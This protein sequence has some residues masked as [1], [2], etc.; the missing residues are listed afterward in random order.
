MKIGIIGSG[1]SGL[2]CAHYLHED[3]DIEI[4]ES[5]DWIG[6]HTHTVD[7]EWQG[8]THAID[9]G[10]IVFNQLTYPNFLKLL[11]DCEVEYQDSSMS[12]G[13][14]CQRTGLEYNA[15]SIDTLFAQRRNIIRPSFWLI[16][17]DI[18]RFYKEADAALARGDARSLGRYLREEGYSTA[19]IEQHIV[20]MAAAVWSAPPSQMMSFPL[21]YLLRFFHNH[22]FTK[23]AGRPQWHVIKGGS[24]EYVRKLVRPFKDKIRLNSKVKSVTRFEDHVELVVAGETLK[25]DEVIM[26]CHSNTALKILTDANHEEK[27]ILGNIPY[28]KNEVTLHTDKSLMPK[29][30][31]AWASWNYRVPKSESG[32]ATVTYWMNKLQGLTGSPDFFVSLNQGLD[33]EPTKIIKT[34]FYDHPVYTRETVKAQKRHHEISGGRTHF[35][36]AYW[37][38]GFHEDGVKSALRVCETIQEKR[39]CDTTQAA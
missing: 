12:F 16:L 15:T 32:D 36:G 39:H 8:Q 24:R 27:D 3:H 6:G 2:T 20:P 18:Y 38:Y 35:C 34:F 31:K 21:E 30:K 19:F 5:S 9:T 13:V 23:L 11:S 1:I 7:V 4:F 28:Q 22:G 37:H 29:A 10:F 25:F 14:L 33:I 17:R 26:A